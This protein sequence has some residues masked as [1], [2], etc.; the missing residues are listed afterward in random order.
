MANLSSNG[1]TMWRIKKVEQSLK[2]LPGK[3]ITDFPVRPKRKPYSPNDTVGSGTSARSESLCSNAYSELSL[4]GWLS[5]TAPCRS[6]SNRS[7]RIA[8]ASLPRIR[9][10]GYRNPRIAQRATKHLDLPV[11]L[12]EAA[13]NCN[14]F[15]SA[16]LSPP[17]AQRLL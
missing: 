5:S 9:L 11:V 8:I 6:S 13:N 10:D 15:H 14:C 1:L 12:L 7:L 16:V 3:S 4:K 2:P 17:V